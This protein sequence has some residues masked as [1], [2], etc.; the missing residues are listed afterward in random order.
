MTPNTGSQTKSNKRNFTGRPSRLTIGSA[1][2][3]I[4]I[5]IVLTVGLLIILLFEHISS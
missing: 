1:K 2:A 5:I 4:S 3:A